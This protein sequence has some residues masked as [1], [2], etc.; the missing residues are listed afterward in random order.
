MPSQPRQRG[1]ALFRGSLRCGNP[2]PIT[3]CSCLN[4]V[5]GVLGLRLYE[6]PAYVVI[7]T[8]GDRVEIRRYALRLAAEVALPAAG[9][10]ARGQAFQLLFDYISGAN[11]SASGADK[12]AMTVPVA[13]REPERVAMTVPV[14]S[15]QT[16]G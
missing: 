14:E 2:F 6:E 10:A 3:W 16:D 8:A 12:I 13:I 4:S 15:E 1:S 5:V 9:E 11:R 7:D